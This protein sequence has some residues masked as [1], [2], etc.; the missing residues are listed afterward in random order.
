MD[1]FLAL[2]IFSRYQPVPDV[3]AKAGRNVTPRCPLVQPYAVILFILIE[4]F[5]YTYILVQKFGKNI[6]ICSSI[7]AEGIKFY[8]MNKFV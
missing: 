7:I 4:E 5:T 2:L 1:D 3:K 6:Y 8:T